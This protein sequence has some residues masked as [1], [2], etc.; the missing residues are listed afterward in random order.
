MGWSRPSWRVK[1]SRSCERMRRRP[2]NE[3]NGSPMAFA[4]MNR[5]KEMMIKRGIACRSR[6]MMYLDIYLILRD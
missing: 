1:R 4:K 3:A 2:P 5:K 6:R